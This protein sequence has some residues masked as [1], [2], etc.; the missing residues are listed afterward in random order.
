MASKRSAVKPR[1]REFVAN[2]SHRSIIFEKKMQV[3]C[4]MEDGQIRPVVCRSVKL[5]PSTVST[6]MKNSDK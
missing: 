4:R 5:H 6:T 1:E 3:F 2:E